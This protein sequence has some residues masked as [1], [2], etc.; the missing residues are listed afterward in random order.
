AELVAIDGEVRLVRGGRERTRAAKRPEHRENR[1]PG[2]QGEQRP[3]Q[4]G[5]ALV[6]RGGGEKHAP[7]RALEGP[8][9]EAPRLLAEAGRETLHRYRRGQLTCD[10][11]P[12]GLRQATPRATSGR[13]RT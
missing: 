2:H 1:G 12:S 8:N 10:Q 7:C 5:E 3:E 4:H 9:S 13:P 6:D 11:V